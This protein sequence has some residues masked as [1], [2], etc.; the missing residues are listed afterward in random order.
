MVVPVNRARFVERLKEL[1]PALV[2]ALTV[3]LALRRLDETDTWWHLA[4]G[5][6]IVQHRAVPSTDTLSYTVPDHPW[7]NVQWLFDVLIY[8][9]YQAG[10][11]TLLVLVSGLAYGLAIAL[12]IRHLRLAL[13]PLA[14]ATLALWVTVIAQERFAIRPEM[15]SYLLL[16]VLLWVYATG[17]RPESRRLWLIPA[18][19]LLWVNC[20]SLFII[21][22]VV[23]G[24]HVAASVVTLLTPTA[25]FG[26]GHEPPVARRV[27]AT[28]AAALLATLVN[29]F[30]A[31]GATFPL[32][33]MSRINWSIPAFSTIG[34][35]A[36]P[37]SDYFVTYS[38]RA[39]QVFFVLSVAIVVLATAYAA[40]ARR[41]VA[42]PQAGRRRRAAPPRLV[43]ALVPDHSETES[44]SDFDLAGLLIFIGLAYVSLQARRNMAIFALGVAPF[45]ARCLATCGRAL[46]LRMRSIGGTLGTVV[47][48]VMPPALAAA[49][50]F[51]TSNG[52]YRWNAETHEFGVGVIDHY[53]PIRAASFVREMG[54]PAPMFND[55]TAGG[56]L[57]WDRPLDRGVYIDGRTEVYDAD[58]F[59]AYI[60]S[61][62]HPKRWQA[63]ADQRGIQTVLFFHRWPNR[64]PLMQWLLRDRRWALL[65]YDEVAMV[66]VRRA[67]NDDL[68]AK[69]RA[70]FEVQRLSIESGL[71]VPASSWRWP[72]ALA[73]GLLSYGSLRGIMGDTSDVV[74]FYTRFVDLHPAVEQELPL[75]L[76][77]AR[78]YA[79]KGNLAVARMHLARAAA[80][81]PSNP[82]VL[83]L[84]KRIGS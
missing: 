41:Q 70:A 49:T 43:P 5:R 34:E 42:V 62:E 16:E 20:H 4:A 6:W 28:G 39:Y 50:W 8:G 40:F 1:S 22:V 52:F 33:L 19:V 27:L 57:A 58:F 77:L 67:S 21:G 80:L 25:R 2:T 75:R 7:I 61:L 63:D 18:V 32:V 53:F 13:G 73:Q 12:L 48:V 3:V 45:V 11:P 81:D 60:D 30:G 76:F 72:V 10:G 51:V 37:F 64:R 47:A 17:R 44:A 69:A 36:R 24:A 29:P 14:A 79:A 78:Y 23:I 66:L 54:L 9:L 74:R 56:Y 15:I 82:S 59:S 65:Y 83:D 26:L 68:V 35:L 38:V 84:R 55:F 71:L 31:T 46:P